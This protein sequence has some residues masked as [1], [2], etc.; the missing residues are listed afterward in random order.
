MKTK[1]QLKDLKQV[2]AIRVNHSKFHS[3]NINELREHLIKELKDNISDFNINDFKEN[4]NQFEWKNRVVLKPKMNR[5]Q[6][7]I[8][9][10][11]SNDYTFE[12]S[13]KKS[14]GTE[15]KDWN[16][17]DKG[18]YILDVKGEKI[19]YIILTEEI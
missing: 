18:F 6:V 2:K 13:D 12:Y 3:E 19:E 11:R 5:E 4:E 14:Y 17:T 10:F 16:L 1:K 9:T 8:L 7:G 15:A